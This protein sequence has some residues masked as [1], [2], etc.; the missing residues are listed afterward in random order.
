MVTV[1]AFK[2]VAIK[3]TGLLRKGMRFLDRPRLILRPEGQGRLADCYT[4]FASFPRS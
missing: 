2:K 4:G 1:F 3:A